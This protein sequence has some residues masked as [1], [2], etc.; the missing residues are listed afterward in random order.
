MQW[1][2]AEYAIIMRGV[3]FGYQIKRRCINKY[4]QFEPLILRSVQ[5]LMVL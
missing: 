5:I 4:L 1:R 3:H 2:K